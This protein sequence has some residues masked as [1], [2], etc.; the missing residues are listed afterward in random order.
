MNFMLLSVSIT[1]IVY[2]AYHVFTI[3]LITIEPG[4]SL[5]NYD[6]FT[7]SL[8]VCTHK[9]IIIFTLGQFIGGIFAIV[10][11]ASHPSHVGWLTLPVLKPSKPIPSMWPDNWNILGIL[12]H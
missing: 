3:H 7:F 6:Y 1:K 12:Q 8:L 2:T 9:N 10:Y 4:S 11:F 5:K